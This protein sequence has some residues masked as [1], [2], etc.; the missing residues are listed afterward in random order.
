MINTEPMTEHEKSEW[1]RIEAQQESRQ[2]IIGQN[3]NN[4]DHYGKREPVYLDTETTGLFVSEGAE[5]LEIAI[6]TESG[7]VL[8]DSFVKPYHATEW[9]EAMLINQITPETVAGA[10]YFHEIAN[11][12][13]DTLTGRT[14]V[15]WNAP[16]DL[17]FLSGL[18]DKS[19]VI[20]AMRE[21]GDFIERTQ[22]HNIS[23]N[24][25][26]K[27]EYTANDLGVEIE[28]QPHRALTDV[29]TT[30]YVRQAW[31][32]GQHDQADLSGSVNVPP[33]QTAD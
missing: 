27:L 15:I 28:G 4:G 21:Y 26:Y 3:G 5:L 8:M 9:P 7:E 32:S 16:F 31:K 11:Q 14:V 13:K 19:N 12:I 6:V 29:L 2:N 10:P 25:R 17:Q 20:C 1:E 23:H 22:P 18:A 30:I 33:Y 24:G